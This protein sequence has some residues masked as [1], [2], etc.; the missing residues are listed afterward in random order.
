MERGKLIYKNVKEHNIAEESL[1]KEYKDLLELFM[2]HRQN[3]DLENVILRPWQSS[4]LEYI[5]PSDREVIWVIGAR[6]NEGK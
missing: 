6:C 2:K 3:I 5:K 1:C 4:L